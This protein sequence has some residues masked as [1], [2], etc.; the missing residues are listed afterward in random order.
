MRY[1]S[2][3]DIFT[4]NAKTR[5]RTI[6][7]AASISD[8]EAKT[9]PDD[10][11][12]SV[13][14][15]FEHIAIVDGGT[16]RIAERLLNAARESGNMSDGSFSLSDDFSQRSAAIAGLKVEAPERVRPT[17]QVSISDAMATMAANVS[18]FDS[19]RD[20]LEKYDLTGA[21][22]PHPFFGDLNAAEWLVVKAGHEARHTAQ[23]ERL[24]EKIRN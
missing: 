11:K 7:L 23:V 1:E 14:E 16:I 9:L 22:F 17:G 10:E 8:V 19:L 12:W 4:A 20:D 24:L 5:E 6:A 13:Q 21:K 18:G 15:I 2:I 3:A